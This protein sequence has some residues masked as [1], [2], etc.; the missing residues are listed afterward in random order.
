[1]ALKLTLKPGEQF[2]INGAVVTNGDRRAIVIVQNKASILRDRDV[3]TEAEATSPAKRVYFLCMLSYLDTDAAEG[4]YPRFV[5]A[6]DEFMQAIENPRMRLTCAQVSFAMMG[7]EYYRALSGCRELIEYE[8]L[9]LGDPDVA[10]R[11]QK[12]A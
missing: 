2:V 7:H 4:Y 11:L 6:M 9:I 3:M 12:S 5:E 1:M 8:A 10:E